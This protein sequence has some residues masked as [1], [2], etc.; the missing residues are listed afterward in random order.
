MRIFEHILCSSS[1]KRMR[2]REMEGRDQDWEEEEGKERTRR[3]QTRHNQEVTM[4]RERKRLN[5][6]GSIQGAAGGWLESAWSSNCCCC[7]RFRRRWDCLRLWLGCE[8]GAMVF[9]LVELGPSCCCEC[10]GVGW[11]CCCK[12]CGG[13]CSG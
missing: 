2:V 11:I 5:G 8:V 3:K 6:K 9:G 12:G 13:C 10:C 1:G 4:M 7:R